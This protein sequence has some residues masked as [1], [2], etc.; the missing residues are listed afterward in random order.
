[1]NF[2]SLGQ[3]KINFRDEILTCCV[4]KHAKNTK[5]FDPVF[6]ICCVVGIEFPRTCCSEAASRRPGPRS[7]AGFAP[8]V[9]DLSTRFGSARERP[10]FY[11]LHCFAFLLRTFH[12]TFF[13]I[14]VTITQ[15]V[16]GRQLQGNQMKYSNVM[17]CDRFDS[18]LHLVLS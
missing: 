13:E 16:H 10:T 6:L 14:P 15:F 18:V 3:K 11:S 5:L 1:M 17:M 9:G 12:S 4:C 8:P 7:C 2:T